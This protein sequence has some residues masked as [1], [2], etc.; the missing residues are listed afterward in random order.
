MTAN[1][2]ALRARDDVN[3]GLQGSRTIGIVDGGRC[4]GGRGDDSRWAGLNGL[5]GRTRQAAKLYLNA[6]SKNP[7]TRRWRVHHDR[8]QRQF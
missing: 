8:S 7:T 6:Q 2:G 3:R 1:D 5:R 4:A